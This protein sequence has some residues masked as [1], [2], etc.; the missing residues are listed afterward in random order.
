MTL[1]L[2][3]AS[4]RRDHG[5]DLIPVIDASKRDLDQNEGHNDSLQTNRVLVLQVVH[6]YNYNVLDVLDL[7]CNRDLDRDKLINGRG[8][9]V[10][11]VDTEEQQQHRPKRSNV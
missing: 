7:L 9:L 8:T 11:E 10:E 2:L 6:F 5:H 3:A 1:N 4:D